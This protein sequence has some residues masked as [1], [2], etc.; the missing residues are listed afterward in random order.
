[1]KWRL[2]LIIHL[3]H[4]VGESFLDWNNVGSIQHALTSDVCTIFLFLHET[5]QRCEQTVGY[6]KLLRKKNP[7]HIA[8]LGIW[9]NSHLVVCG[10][11]C[12]VKLERFSPRIYLFKIMVVDS[13]G[14]DAILCELICWGRI[15][16]ESQ[17]LHQSR[18]IPSVQVT[19]DR[20]RGLPV[21]RALACV[22][23]NL[24]IRREPNLLLPSI[25]TDYETISVY[26]FEGAFYEPY[27]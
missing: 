22:E 14:I 24:R 3:D 13:I 19:F 1:M 7:Q 8:P 16:G 10:W 5:E 18:D 26:D 20:H 23:E 17:V 21:G 11:G 25:Q 9:H 6:L 4:S 15:P 27:Q 2:R 12:I